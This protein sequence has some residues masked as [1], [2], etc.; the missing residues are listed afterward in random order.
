[1]AKQRHFGTETACPSSRAV[2]KPLPSIRLRASGQSHLTSSTKLSISNVQPLAIRPIGSPVR[3]C[4]RAPVHCLEAVL[5]HGPVGR[6]E[7]LAIYLDHEVGTDSDQVGVVGCVVDLAQAQP[8]R[9]DGIAVGFSI[10]DD[11]CRLQQAAQSE[12]AYGA[13]SG[14]R[15]QDPTTKLGLV[16]P[17]PYYLFGVAALRTQ[18]SALMNRTLSSSDSTNSCRAMSSSITYTGNTGTK[19]PVL[20]LRSRMI[21]SSSS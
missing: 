1:M 15:L 20:I 19:V 18:V 3:Q 14:V 8:V 17:S 10:A 21:G 4:Q 11:V 7:Q 16:K 13:L 2:P 9:N 5:E 6:L 12:I